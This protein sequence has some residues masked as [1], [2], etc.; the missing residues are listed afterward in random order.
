MYEYEIDMMKFEK[1]LSVFLIVVMMLM[2]ILAY[3]VS[4]TSHVDLNKV[5]LMDN[6]KKDCQKQDQKQTQVQKTSCSGFEVSGFI[7]LFSTVA[8]ATRSVVVLAL[9]LVSIG[10]P[11]VYRLFKPPRTA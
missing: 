6:Y 7:Q 10:L 1:K 5:T 2:P 11:P 3:N 9:L 8:P 4:A